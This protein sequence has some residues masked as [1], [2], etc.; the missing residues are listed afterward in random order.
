MRKTVLV[1]FAVLALAGCKRQLKL[2]GTVTGFKQGTDT[3][4]LHVVS[5]KGASVTCEPPGYGCK[6]ADVGASGAVDVELETQAGQTDKKIYL[7]GRI[8]PATNAVV[9]DPAASMPPAVKIAFNKHIDCV[10]KDCT[11]SIDVVPSGHLSLTAPPGTLVEI[12]GDKL[13]VGSDGHLD[14]PWSSSPATKDQTLAKLFARDAVT[15]GSSNLALTF[16]DKKKLSTRFEL[17][18]DGAAAALT[19][20]LLGVAKGPVLFPWEKSAPAKG[21]AVALYCRGA[22][23][24]GGAPDGTLA[25]LRVV[26]LSEEKALRKITCSYTNRST[27]KAATANLT[28]HDQLATAYERATGRKLGAKSFQASSHCDGEVSAKLGA[29]LG[30]QHSAPDGATIAQWAASFA[31]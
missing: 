14:A 9:V 22:C 16:P 11:G 4:M 21:K 6:R 13:T 10:A 24:V 19:P 26:A 28:M 3:L 20:L 17:T 31:R 8:G 29:S 27:G 23:Y 1:C 7:K 5:E 25:D 2:G 12:G 15:F 18:T 30:D